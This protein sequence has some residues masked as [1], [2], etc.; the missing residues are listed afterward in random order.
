MSFCNHKIMP[1]DICTVIPDHVYIVDTKFLRDKMC[2]VTIIRDGEDAI[3]VEAGSTISVPHTLNALKELGIAYGNVKY[4]FIT[5]AHL[6]HSGGTGLILQSLPNCTVVA[7]PAAAPHITDP[8]DKLVPAAIQVYGEQVFNQDYPGIVGMSTDRIIS[9]E[10]GSVHGAASPLLKLRVIYAHGHA[11][12]HAIFYSEAAKILFAGDGLGFSFSEINFCPL[13]CT[14]PTQFD[15]KAWRKTVDAVRTLDIDYLIA[16]HFECAEKSSLQRRWDCILH[17]LDDYE[18]LIAASKGRD[19]V[20]TKYMGIIQKYMA[21]YDVKI[22]H[23][24]VYAL[25]YGD[26]NVDGLWYRVQR[27]LAK[28]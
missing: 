15:A 16:T 7:H 23:E 10:D 13:L 17:Q 12:H 8:H 28:A 2:G 18:T 26:I 14:T 3:L 5:H 24:E 22:S 20:K 9:A 27:N 25:I 6:D 11:F 19:D 21:E 4:M 1:E